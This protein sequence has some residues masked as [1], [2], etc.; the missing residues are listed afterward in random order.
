MYMHCPERDGLR[1]ASI[2]TQKAV[3]NRLARGSIL[4]KKTTVLKK[5]KKKKVW[6][7]EV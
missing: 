4:R 3:V 6:G 1:D 2:P 5:K 7:R